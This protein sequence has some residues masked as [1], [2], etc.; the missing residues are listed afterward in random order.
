MNNKK[1]KLTFL[2]NKE[3]LE[4]LYQKFLEQQ[5]KHPLNDNLS[6]IHSMFERMI[7]RINDFIECTEIDILNLKFHTISTL[8]ILFTLYIKDIYPEV[9]DC[10]IYKYTRN[11]VK[12]IL[13]YSERLNEVDKVIDLSDESTDMILNR[14]KNYNENERQKK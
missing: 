7:K 8:S 2:E 4:E 10:E 14:I 6:K 13:Y 5:I 11:L 3:I 12:F 1:S 9:V